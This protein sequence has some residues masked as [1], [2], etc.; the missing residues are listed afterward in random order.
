MHTTGF[1][2]VSAEPSEFLASL[3]GSR[4]LN[5]SDVSFVDTQPGIASV[6]KMSVYRKGPVAHTNLLSAES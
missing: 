3:Q 1:S 4:V 6:E 2:I 5:N